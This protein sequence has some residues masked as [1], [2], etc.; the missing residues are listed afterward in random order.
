MNTKNIPPRMVWGVWGGFLQQATG[1][2]CTSAVRKFAQKL[3]FFV[4]M[5]SWLLHPGKKSTCFTWAFSP[6]AKENHLP[7]H[8]FSGFELLIF[9][10]VSSLDFLTPSRNLDTKQKTRKHTFWRQIVAMFFCY[11]KGTPSK[12]DMK[13]WEMFLSKWMIF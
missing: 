1:L 11:K 3:W 13:V 10:G 4:L 5:G 7:N 8:H 6:L 9:W 2:A 12:T